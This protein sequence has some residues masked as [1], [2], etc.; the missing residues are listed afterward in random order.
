VVIKPIDVLHVDIVG[1]V[2]NMA[3]KKKDT[4]EGTPSIADDKLEEWAKEKYPDFS[5]NLDLMRKCWEQEHGIDTTVHDNVREYIKK[6]VKDVRSGES[7]EVEVIIARKKGEYNYR[8]CSKLSHRKKKDRDIEDEY[9]VC[10]CGNKGL[11]DYTWH[12]YFVGDKTYNITAKTN[13]PTEEESWLIEGKLMK[14]RGRVQ[15]DKYDGGLLCLS[16][17]S[18]VDDGKTKS[19]EKLE[20][21]CAEVVDTINLYRADGGMIEDDFKK[22]FEKKKFGVSYKSVLDSFNIEEKDGRLVVVGD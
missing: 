12:S 5:D 18:V 21:I 4:V 20:R 22:W 3:K 11:R 9:Y 7:V 15:K 6:D 8:G 14:L 19:N 16:V 17:D 13:Q 10:Q 2:I 1:V